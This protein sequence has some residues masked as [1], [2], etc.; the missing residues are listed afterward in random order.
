MNILI[1]S[2]TK[3]SHISSAILALLIMAN[4]SAPVKCAQPKD[5]ETKQS[6][7]ILATVKKNIYATKKALWHKRE[8]FANC[9]A[10]CFIIYGIVKALSNPAEHEISP[11]G[12]PPAQP[13]AVV[14]PG[15]S[16]AARPA[17]SQAQARRHEAALLARTQ[18]ERRDAERQSAAR[19]AERAALRN[20]RTPLPVRAAAPAVRTH[21]QLAPQRTLTYTQ[22]PVVRQQ[23]GDCGLHAIANAASVNECINRRQPVEARRIQEYNPPFYNQGAQTLGLINALSNSNIMAL[24][25]R[26]FRMNNC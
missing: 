9:A 18:R 10:A 12:S 25:Q 8:L 13:R 6:V 22:I 16:Q 23:H 2:S 14:G 24:A 3:K 11:T 21:R 5:K 20:N 7:G 4:A 19:Q 1:Q 17:L 15:N 26:D